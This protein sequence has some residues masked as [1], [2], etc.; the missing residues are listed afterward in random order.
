MGGGAFFTP[1]LKMLKH[2]FILDKN[3]QNGTFLFLF[4]YQ[5]SLGVGVT[6]LVFKR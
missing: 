6:F 3:I 4:D 2:F 5:S 1:F